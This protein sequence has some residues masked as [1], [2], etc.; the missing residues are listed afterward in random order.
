[1]RADERNPTGFVPTQAQR[2]ESERKGYWDHAIR[3]GLEYYVSGRFAT[4]HGFISVNANI[5]HHGV[6]LLLKA[7]LAKDDPIEKIRLYGNP[8]KGYYHDIVQLWQEFKLRQKVP[9]PVE[10][11]AI[12][13]GLH[14]FEHIRYP[15][16]LIRD[17]AMIRIDIFD[18]ENLPDENPGMREKQYALKLPQ[19]DRLMGLLF[20]ASGANP[21]A[22]LPRIEND[23][24]AMIY[25]DMVR[26]TLFGRP[27]L[28]QPEGKSRIGLLFRKWLNA[29]GLSLGIVGVVFIW[30]WGPPQPSFEREVPLAVSE[31]TPLPGGK[32]AGQHTA[33]VKDQESR[34]RLMSSIGLAF[35]LL[36]FATQLANEFLP[37]DQATP[38][39]AK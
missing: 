11:D 15:E 7:C 9:P 27:K 5:L 39:R 26:P 19:I 36:G 34:Y 23:E 10:F 21:P 1:M 22:F 37:R 3:Y 13:E 17:G 6:E 12:V 29:I 24:Q 4:A 33:E 31:G 35:I 32:T 30:I 20:A 8:K 14:E 2:D 25:Y 28:T 18:V 38:P 16:F